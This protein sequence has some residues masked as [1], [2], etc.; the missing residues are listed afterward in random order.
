MLDFLS[1][2]KD[3]VHSLQFRWRD[4][5]YINIKVELG[6]KVKTMKY[7]RNKESTKVPKNEEQ[8]ARHELQT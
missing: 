6:T 8:K 7:Q 2:E 4:K 5:I 1:K 3:T